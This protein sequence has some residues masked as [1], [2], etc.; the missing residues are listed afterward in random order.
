MKLTKLEPKFIKKLNPRIGPLPVLLTKYINN[1]PQSKEMKS[2]AA[3]AFDS[4]V[5]KTAIPYSNIIAKS[6][7][8]RQ[9]IHE[10]ASDHVVAKSYDKVALA[11]GR[12]IGGNKKK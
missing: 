9:S 1:S 6:H 8:S 5:F 7:G 10:Y 3:E 11:V 12:F 4:G 2:V